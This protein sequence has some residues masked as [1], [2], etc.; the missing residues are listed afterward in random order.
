MT[1]GVVPLASFCV[2]LPLSESGVAGSGAFVVPQ[3]QF[4]PQLHA[5]DP[6]AANTPPVQQLLVSMAATSRGSALR[7][8]GL[9]TPQRQILAPVQRQGPGDLR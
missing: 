9:E 7:W 3:P 8:Q 6:D 2:E 4:T 1:M 5:E